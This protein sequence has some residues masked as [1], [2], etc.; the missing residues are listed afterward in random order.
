VWSP[1]K[2]HET[3]KSISGSEKI[4]VR[5]KKREY[6]QRRQKKFILHWHVRGALEGTRLFG[7]FLVDQKVTEEEEEEEK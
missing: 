7:Y 4:T 6:S 2:I 3:I 5:L 1:W